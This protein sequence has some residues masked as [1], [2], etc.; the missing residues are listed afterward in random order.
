MEIALRVRRAHFDLSL[1][2]QITLRNT[3]RSHGFED[4]VIFFLNLV[5]NE[6]VRDAT[7]NH[8]VIFRAI[9]LF[10]ENGLERST[11]F[12]HENDLVRA[13]V[14]IILKFVVRLF[15]ARAIRDHVLI[16]QD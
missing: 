9:S 15:G 10:T 7:R 14:A 1:L 11:T 2:V 8:Y 16:K 4:Q 6:P 12:E 13:A 3:D 5:W